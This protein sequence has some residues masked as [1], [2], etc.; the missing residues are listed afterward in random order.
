MEYTNKIMTPYYQERIC[1][2][3]EFKAEIRLQTIFHSEIVHLNLF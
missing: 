1:Q 3:V 2:N